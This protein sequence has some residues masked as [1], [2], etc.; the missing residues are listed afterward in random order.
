MESQEISPFQEVNFNQKLRLKL[1]P[2][3]F[4]VR[5]KPIEVASRCSPA[6]KLKNM[7]EMAK[8]G[9]SYHNLHCWTATDRWGLFRKGPQSELSISAH[10]DWI[11]LEAGRADAYHR[12]RLSSYFHSA[13]AEMNSPL[14]GYL[15]N[16]SPLRALVIETS[17]ENFCEGCLT[18]LDGKCF[19]MSP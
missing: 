2:S 19:Y 11:E 6:R 16:T 14:S 7:R 13:H 8:L 3:F 15:Q 10:T 17:T 1:M 9:V 4:H 12:H 5:Q 18:F